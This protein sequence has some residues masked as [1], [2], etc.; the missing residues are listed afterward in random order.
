MS[1]PVAAALAGPA[2]AR[3][4]SGPRLSPLVCRLCAHPH[5]PAAIAI[6]PECLGPL[7]PA[8]DPGRRLPSRAEIEARPRSIWRYREWLPVLDPPAVSTDTGFTPLI[9]APA[10]AR[11]LGVRSVLVKN[12]AVSHPTLSFKDRVVAVAINAAV[13]LGLDTVGCAS[14]GNL[15]NA[16][17]AHAARA[18]LRA[19]VFVPDDL[20]IG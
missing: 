5:P 15:A 9:D 20:E 11:A 8:Y 16:V 19:W 14:T 3:V 17:A 13:G 18:G 4:P 1:S 7:E 12:D 2:P 6:C 10:L